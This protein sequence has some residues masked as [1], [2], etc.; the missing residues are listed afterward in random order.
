MDPINA[1]DDADNNNVNNEDGDDGE[2]EAQHICA[3][4]VC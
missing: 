1:N 3:N 4:K 2:N